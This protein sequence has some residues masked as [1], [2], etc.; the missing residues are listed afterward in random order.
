MPSIDCF[1]KTCQNSWRKAVPLLVRLDAGLSP[2]GSGF[3]AVIFLLLF[4]K[5]HFTVWLRI[6]IPPPPTLNRL[7]TC[8]FCGISSDVCQFY[9]S[10]FVSRDDNDWWM[11]ALWVELLS[12]SFFTGKRSSHYL[13]AWNFPPALELLLAEMHNETGACSWYAEPVCH[14]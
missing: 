5:I 6:T 8:I 3:N 4:C 13:V 12:F 9:Y 7:F 11:F 14:G 2:Q 10:C 1:S